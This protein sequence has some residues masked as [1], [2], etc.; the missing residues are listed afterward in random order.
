MKPTLLTKTS[1]IWGDSN[2]TIGCEISPD[3]LC[4]LTSTASD[5]L[6][7]LYNTPPPIPLTKSTDVGDDEGEICDTSTHTDA[8]AIAVADVAADALGAGDG[9]G[10]SVGSDTPWNSILSAKCGDSVRSYSWYPLMN[11]YQPQTCAFL[12]VSR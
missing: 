4:I 3:G 7:R 12:A 1:D 9:V 2:F 5:H 8:V 11:S 10:V 6:L